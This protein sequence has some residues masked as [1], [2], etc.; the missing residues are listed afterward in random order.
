MILL[1]IWML[2]G[3]GYWYVAKHH[4]AIE[5]QVSYEIVE[6]SGPFYFEQGG[7]DLIPTE[8]FQGYRDQISLDQNTN[9]MLIGFLTEQEASSNQDLGIQRALALSEHLGLPAGRIDIQSQIVEDLNANKLYVSISENSFISNEIDLLEEESMDDTEVELDPDVKR[10]SS[11]IASVYFIENS[12]EY[13]DAD[14][15]ISALE[16][17]VAQIQRKGNRILVTGYFQPGKTSK[18][19]GQRR[20]WMIKDKLI[21][22][23]INPEKI[24]VVTKKLPPND[25][26]KHVRKVEFL[27]LD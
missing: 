27:V 24:M 13:Q 1:G 21:L 3:A 14:Q 5:D 4:C 9:Y 16:A 11:S 19:I 20:A 23:G 18:S 6:N 17:I 26:L 15:V 22:K 7:K 2:V 25:H 8:K 10:K 12:T